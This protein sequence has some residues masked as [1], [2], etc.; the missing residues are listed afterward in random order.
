MAAVAIDALLKAALLMPAL[1]AA[2]HTQAVCKWRKR[3][4]Q[5]RDGRRRTVSA[6]LL[7]SS[8][9]IVRERMLE[10]NGSSEVP[11]SNADRRHLQLPCAVWEAAAA[12]L[13]MHGVMTF[14]P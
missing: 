3:R 11:T 5:R 4:A 9:W 1:R 14:C 6:H 2:Q 7:G 10:R 13:K 12:S 8:T